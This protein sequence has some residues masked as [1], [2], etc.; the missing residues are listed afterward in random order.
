MFQ[1][2]PLRFYLFG[3]SLLLLVSACGT[4]PPSS[5]VTSSSP[6]MSASPPTTTDHGGQGGQIIETGQYH[7]ELVVDREEAGLHLDFYI[8]EGEAHTPVATAT[9]TAEIQQPDGQKVTLPM[10]YDAEDE[11]YTARL[12]TAL[13][14]EYS[15]VI[16]S[17]IKGEK[18]NSRFR[19]RHDP[20]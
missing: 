14:G 16:L 11:H 5:T 20:D 12:A 8:Q 2:L 4:A 15:V 9:V 17:D 1:L 18:V 19:F 10:T 13:A 3:L 7:L 6:T